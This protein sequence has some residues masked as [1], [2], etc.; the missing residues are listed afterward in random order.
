VDIALMV[1]FAI[2]HEGA[3]VIAAVVTVGLEMVS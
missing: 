3:I 2:I 1:A